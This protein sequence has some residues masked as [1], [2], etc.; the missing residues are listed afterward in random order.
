M[1]VKLVGSVDNEEVQFP[2]A[3]GV[4]LI[5]RSDDATLRIPKPSI[6]RHH[7]EIR[8]LGGNITV[9]DLGS[10]NGTRVNGATVEGTMVLQTGDLLELANLTFRLEGPESTQQGLSVTG[11]SVIPNAEISWDEVRSARG[12]KKDLQSLLF[13]VLAEAGDLLTIP[14][15]P[16]EMY[17]PILDLVE[18]ALLKPERIFVL[19]VEEIGQEPVHAASRIKGYR[20]EESLVLSRTMI[21]QVI[22]DKKSFLASDSLDQTDM[23]GMMSMIS[24]GIRSAIAV[25]LFD[26]ED[27]IGILYADDSRPQRTFSRDQLAAF[28]LLANTIAVALTHARYHEMEAEKRRQDAEVSAAEDILANILPKS[29]PPLEGYDVLAN[30]EPCFEVGGDLYFAQPLEDGKYAFLVGDVTGKGLGAALLVSHI[31]SLTRFMLSE[32]WEPASLVEQLS[33]QTFL[34]T[35]FVRFA[36]FFLGYLDPATGHI[37]Y[38]NAGHNPPY[39]VRQNGEVEECPTCGLP[40]GMME[41]SKYRSGEITLGSGDLLAVFSD[42][43]PEAQT[44]EDEEY[45]EENFKNLLVTRRTEPLDQ[46]FTVLQDELAKFRGEAPIGD[47]VTLLTL[48]RR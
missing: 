40:V 8:V 33:R 15:S 9:Q 17:D 3:E 41:D 16:E 42:G 19:L 14:R 23:D 34:C 1:E 29:L 28:T 2:L 43:I 20:G 6:S 7:A 11:Q 25:P 38:V 35:D 5:G 12:Q 10:H 26:N 21:Q 30:L 47:D 4:Y 32:G 27:V 37:Q 24:Q 44:L 46:I 22:E 39:L 31:M 36:T 48:R 45:G 13:R 18:T